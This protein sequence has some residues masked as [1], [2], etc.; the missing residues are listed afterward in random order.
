MIKKKNVLL[1]KKILNK[2]S[3]IRVYIYIYENYRFCGINLFKNYL[4]KIPSAS[5]VLCKNCI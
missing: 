4:M 1:K 2:L 5:N 3:S